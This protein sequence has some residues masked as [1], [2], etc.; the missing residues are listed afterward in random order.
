MNLASI[1]PPSSA[2]S[3]L[4]LEAGRLLWRVRIALIL[5]EIS[6]LGLTTSLLSASLPWPQLIALIGMHAVLGLWAAYAAQHLE[7]GGVERVDTLLQLAA[8]AAIIGGIVYFTGGFANPFISLLLVPLILG[9]VLLPSRH[10]WGLAIWV[11]MIYTI[12]MSFYQ[13][14]EMQVSEATAMHL[15]L[16]GMWLN[17]LLTVALV[18]VFVGA[19]AAALRRRDAELAQAR[20]QRLR[21]E[22][23][24]ALGLQAASAAHDLATPLASVRL[25]LDELQQTF[26]GDEDLMP[27]FNLIADQLTRV[28]NVLARLSQ[29]ARS[30][31]CVA[32][33]ALP[34]QQWLGR[35]LEHWGLLHPQARVE[36]LI[37]ADL[38]AIEDDPALEAILMTLLNNA[39][40]VSP[41]HIRLHAHTRHDQLCFE[42]IDAGSGMGH[43]PAGWGVGLDLARAALERLGGTLEMADHAE[44]GVMAC[45]T[46]P[47]ST[48][49]DHEPPCA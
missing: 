34:V 43:K 32:G 19:L 13:P 48:L 39:A 26:S 20:E 10:S 41:Q 16:Q 1:L 11:G 5:G 44:G 3:A 2:N 47:L 9:A 7:R 18:A 30:R 4:P 6:M 17:F 28:E 23:L 12:L 14:I 21:D 22:Q 29:A 36:M 35:T 15:H 42:V 25:T 40:E 37:A 31:E 46:L 38:P 49:T 27:P 45:A 24:F 8:D 33:P